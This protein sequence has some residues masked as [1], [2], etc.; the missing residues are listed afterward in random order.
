MYALLHA[1][2]LLMRSSS[3]VL[4]LRKRGAQRGDRYY[5][6]CTCTNSWVSS[7]TFLSDSAL[8]PPPPPPSPPLSRQHSDYTWSVRERRLTAPPQR[9]W[10]LLSLIAKKVCAHGFDHAPAHYSTTRDD[11]STVHHCLSLSCPFHPCTVHV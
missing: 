7:Q 2:G 4:Q 6:R 3:H 11:T 5:N 1:H 8:R 9:G 10:G